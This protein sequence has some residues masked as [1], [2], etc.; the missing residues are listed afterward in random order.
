MTIF[1]QI[2]NGRNFGDGW[3]NFND[4]NQTL[5]SKKGKYDDFVHWFKL[6]NAHA[7]LFDH[8]VF[9]PNDEMVFHVFVSLIHRQWLSSMFTYQ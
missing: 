5:F 8:R 3:V 1:Y 2:C 4:N 7:C 9:N 6:F